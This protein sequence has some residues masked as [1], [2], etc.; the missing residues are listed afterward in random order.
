MPTP[1]PTACDDQVVAGPGGAMTDE[2]G[3]ITGDLTVRTTRQAD[4]RVAIT[5]QY[6]GA[7]E[8]YTL[9]GSPVAVPDGQLEDYHHRVLDAVQADTE[10]VAPR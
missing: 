3:V 10:A 2:V 4:N 8:W 1:E 7:D 5:V 6:T 9:T